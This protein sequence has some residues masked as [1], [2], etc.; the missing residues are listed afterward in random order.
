MSADVGEKENVRDYANKAIDK[1]KNNNKYDENKQ[2]K[3]QT[4]S[5]R[6]N[7][8]DFSSHKLKDLKQENR[9]SNM[10]D[11]GSMLDYYDLTTTRGK[12]NKKKTDNSQERNK[13]KIFQLTEI[14]I[15]ESITVKDLSTELKKTSGEIIKKLLGLGILATINNELDFDTAFLIA[16][17]WAT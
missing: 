16:Q 17:E 5:R 15:P 2:N 9:L 7:Y 14:T 3:K 8:E 1:Q 12:R 11:E 6:N 10:F 13:Q 4:K